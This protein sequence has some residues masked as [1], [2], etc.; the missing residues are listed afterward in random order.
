YV[1]ENCTACGNCF[2]VCP[3]SAIPGLV[4]KVSD[5]FAA[6]IARVERGMPTQHLRR[7]TRGVEKR[8]RKLI[9]AAGDAADMRELMDRAVLET[10]AA[11]QGEPDQKAAMEQ[12][13]GLMMQALGDYQFAV[14]KPYWSTRE[15]KQKGSGGLFSITINPYTCKGCNEC[16]EVCDDG[17]LVSAPQTTQTIEEMRAKWDVWLDLPTT[18]P[19]FIRIDD[20]DDKI[21]ALETL[22]LDKSN[23][24]SMVS[25]DGSCMGC[26]EKT[27]IHLFTST[28]SA[29]MQGR[30]KRHLADLD[31]LIN[32]LETHIRLKLAAKIDLTNTAAISKAVDAHK[33]ADLRLADLSAELDQDRSAEPVD[34]EWLTWV[35]G[36]LGTL[37]HLK[38][39][40]TAVQP[41]A[42]MGI[43]NATGC[44][45]VWGATFPFNPYPF[46][47][48]NHLF[49]D[50][51]SIALGLFEG[52]MRKMGEGF[53]AI[54]MA[55]LEL[56]RGYNPAEHG[57]ALTY[58]GWKDFS[59]EEWLLCPPVVAV[60]GD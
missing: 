60:G 35:T 50:S 16:I 57:E 46:P 47:W 39:Q 25:G 53:K 42:S 10:L 58:F 22:L 17:A 5:I 54:R 48:S 44:S 19:D 8:L 11:F 33:D 13:F 37:R 6:A 3:D 55:R 21:G 2:S 30:V 1:P 49:Q 27:V 56:E 18:D 45:S 43:V 12:E 34:P 41:R 52:H 20:L 15:K 32:R 31:D 38:A 40:Y 51:P 23:Y 26:G 7:E 29:L 14:T 59:D 28:V 4:N 24:R 9:E 36:L